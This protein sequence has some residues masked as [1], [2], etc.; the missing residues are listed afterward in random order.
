MSFGVHIELN[1]EAPWANG[2]CAYYAIVTNTGSAPEEAFELEHEFFGPDGGQLSR[3]GL[4]GASELAPG[5]QHTTQ[6]YNV[7][8]L[9]PGTHKLRVSVWQDGN[10][11]ADHVHEFQVQ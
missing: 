11:V 10:S 8:P 7:M 1:T 3:S 4:G 5:S 9:V 2:W 6:E